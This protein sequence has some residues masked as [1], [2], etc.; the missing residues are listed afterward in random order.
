MSAGHKLFAPSKSSMWIACPGSMAFPQNQNPDEGGSSYADDGSATHWFGSELLQHG[1]VTRLVTINGKEYILD[2]E[3][4]ERVHGYVDDVRRRAIGGYLFVEQFV[5]LSHILGPDQGGTTDVAIA[6]PSKRMGIIEDLKD[7]AGEKVYASHQG[8][9]NPQLALYALGMLPSFELFGPIDEVLLVIYQPKLNHIDEFSITREALLAFGAKAKAA[10]ELAGAA[11]VAGPDSLT[12]AGYLNPGE[13][14]CR[15]CRA[16]ANCPGLAQFVA[17]E[18]R[19][20]FDDAS[21]ST[22]VARDTKNLAKHYQSVPLIEDWCRAVKVELQKLVAEGEQVIGPDGKPYKFVE[23]KEGA[24]KWTD[25]N[26]ATAALVGQLGPKAYTEPK[27]LT[28]PSAAKLL[29]KAKTKALWKDIFEPLIS[30]P[31]GQPIL[32][33]GSDPRPPVSGVA[34]AEDFA[35]DV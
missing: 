30:R 1:H 4:E 31:R 14:Q 11:M 5:D 26:A 20:E 33:V 8:E 27:L 19:L 35:D 25:E 21:G 29:D 16:K 3:R 17:D 9:P 23:G 22:I 24:R 10:V 18:V 32:T 12:T 7:G 13:K 2:E 6:L 34:T 15:W 28:A